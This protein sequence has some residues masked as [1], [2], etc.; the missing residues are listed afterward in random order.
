MQDQFWKDSCWSL[1]FVGDNATDKGWLGTTEGAHQSVQLLSVKGTDS[2]HGTTLLLLLLATTRWCFW[3]NCW[4]ENTDQVPLGFLEKFDDRGVKR[5]LVFVEPSVKVVSYISGVMLADEVS[6]RL[7]ANLWF[8]ESGVLLFM[9]IV[10]FLLEGLI[11]SLGDNRLF[12][13]SCML[14]HCCSFLRLWSSLVFS[15]L[16]H[17]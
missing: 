2:L 12:L 3:F 13:K 1:D 8:N 14:Y 5:I 15:V 4:E 17:L 11:S 10:Q 6:N 9:S 16:E 7:L